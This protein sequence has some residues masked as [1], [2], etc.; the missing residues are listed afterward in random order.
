MIKRQIPTYFG[1]A[2]LFWAT[3]CRAESLIIP[4]V[5]DGGGWQTTIVLANISLT[6]TTASLGFLQQTGGTATQIWNPAILETGSLQNLNLAAGSSLFLHTAGAAVDTTAGWAQ[7]QANPAVVAYAI[8]T[9]RIQGRPDQ[10]GTAEAT[11]AVSRV[12][13]PFDNSGGFV[14]SIA[15]ANPT[16]ANESIAVGIQPASGASTHPAPLTILAQGHTAFA[17]SDQFPSTVGQRGLLELY[18]ATGSISAL[19]LRFNPTG[20][21]T[22]APV[23]PQTGSPILASDPSSGSGTPLFKMITIHAAAGPFPPPAVGQPPLP[24]LGIT[25]ISVLVPMSNGS[26]YSFGQVAGVVLDAKGSGFGNFVASWNQVTLSGRTLV[27]TDL[28]A[29]TSYMSGGGVHPVVINP[30][31]LSVTLAPTGD[32]TTGNVSGA[33]SLVSSFATVSGS[34]EGTYTAE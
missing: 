12:L 1:A 27:F 15:I 17:I 7:V 31:S 29:P 16:G 32:G 34:F 10:D 8:F 23:Y 30:G 26:G 18:A 9:Q 14:T 2:L 3:S 22:T 25:G 20:S 11:T 4:H 13:I 6:A 21:F 28:V 24:E 19:A 33:I 5:V